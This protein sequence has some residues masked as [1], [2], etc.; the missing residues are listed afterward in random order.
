MGGKNGVQ[1]VTVIHVNPQTRSVTLM[2]E[3]SGEGFYSAS[4]LNSVQLIRDGQTES[5]DVT[6]GK[7]HWRGYTT[8]VEGVIFNDEL[9][10]TRDDVLLGKNGKIVNAAIRRIML[11]NASPFPTL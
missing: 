2:R 5:F 9:T 8:F 3:G 6:P 7:S 10:V 11:L 4:D 1:T